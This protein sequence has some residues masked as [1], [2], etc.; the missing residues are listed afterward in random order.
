M[1]IDWAATGSMVAGIG[2]WAGVAALVW[3]TV[4]GRQSLREW[5]QQKALEREMSVAEEVLTASYVIQAAI[6][7]LYRAIDGA[8]ISITLFSGLV[9]KDPKVASQ[10]DDFF[11]Q[12]SRILLQQDHERVIDLVSKAMPAAKA[13][14]DEDCYQSLQKLRSAYLRL[15]SIKQLLSQESELDT[16]KLEM[17]AERFQAMCRRAL[18][19][20]DFHRRKHDND[21]IAECIEILE[22]SLIPKIRGIAG[23]SV[24]AH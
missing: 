2:T 17:T 21:S 10:M 16:G 4:K 1:A 15:L 18:T 14:L 24:A 7:E 11:T 5:K 23:I 19:N 9:Q 12:T 6:D 20:I 8:K 13:F 3:A 22:K